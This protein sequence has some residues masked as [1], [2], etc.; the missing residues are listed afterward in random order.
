MNDA[1]MNILLVEDNT[2]DA[3][4]VRTL[5][6]EF[7]PGKFLLT[8]AQ[9]LDAALHK[10]AEQTFHAVLLDLSLPDSH[11]M[12]TLERVKAAHPEIPIVVMSGLN[13]EQI[14]LQAVHSGAQDYLVKGRVDGH[15]MTR[16]I[17]YAIE[18]KH[19]EEEL[20][21]ARD[22]LE[23]RVAERT[24]FLK[25]TI[26]RLHEEIT[27]REHAEEILRKERDFSSAI[28]D[29]V[30][31]LVMVLDTQGR[32]VRCNR[33]CE[34]TTGYLE[35]EIKDKSAWD[36]FLSHD[37]AAYTRRVFQTLLERKVPNK[38]ESHW[39][40][41]NG[42]RRL[43]SWSNT[44]ILDA[45]ENVE[46]VIATG[47]DIT[48]LRRAEELERQR[49]LELAHVSRLSTMGEM[50]TEIAHE[51]NQPLCAIA[52]YADTCVRLM[53]ADP[54]EIN[55]VRQALREIAAQAERASEVVRRVRKFVRK[56]EAEHLPVDINELVVDVVNLTR[57]EARWHQV[58][59]HTQLGAVLPAVNGDKIL[60][61]QV[62]VNLV[63][64][65]IEAIAANHNPGGLI[66]ICTLRGQEG[67]VEITVH[68]SG[69]GLSLETI[70]RIFQPFYTTKPNGMGMGLSISLSIV[71]AHNGHLWAEPGAECGVTFHLVLPAIMEETNDD[72]A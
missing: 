31:A 67:G 69:A 66:E 3:F 58:L 35:R 9:G 38:Y 72:A 27:E 25:V 30:G 55:E 42:Q 21:K 15:G 53:E 2:G 20:R 64:N 44:V 40:G 46:H 54:G 51:L 60:L 32:V 5:L 14:A 39:C 19:V 37:E 71:K 12:N 7:A 17:R 48:E 24:S 56:E 50:A 23:Q 1:P 47:I 68:D 13:D 43:I 6:E 34:E 57:V 11:G 29:T 59:V 49:M 10:F 26:R 70:E 36:V 61:E 63:R 16:V 4:L 22:L 18:R 8:H 33:S 28:L 62:L 41:K 52:S 45:R 65:A